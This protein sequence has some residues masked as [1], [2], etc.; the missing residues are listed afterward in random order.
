MTDY[1]FADFQRDDV[2]NEYGELE[3][4][5][6]FVYEACPDIEAIRTKVYAK[7]DAYNEKYP[8]K[9]MSLVIFDDALRHLLRI[10]RVINSPSGNMLLVGVGGSGKQSLTKLASFIAKQVMFQISLTKSYN[11]NSLKDDVKNLYIE[12]G[13]NGRQVTFI[14]TDAEVRSETFLEAINSLLGTG[15]IPGLLNKEDREVIP[16]SC[17]KVYMDEVGVKGEDPSQ[18][19]LWNFFIRRVKDCLH[20]VLAF[21]PVGVK[22]RER[23][24][25]FP[26]LFS[27]CSI[28][29]FLAWP[30]EALISVSSKALQA[31]KVD[32]SSEVKTELEKHMGRVHDLV[33]Q[34]TLEYF[35]KL[36]R[37]V[38]VTP[39]SYL[40]FIDMY[41]S[42]Y[43]SKYDAI[44]VESQS[45]VKGLERLAEASA[46]VEE[47]K[48]E[49]KQ[50][51]IKLK[52]ASDLTE[53]FLKELEVEN[54]KAQTKAD[55]VAVVTETCEAQRNQ[56]QTERDIANR[57][58]EQAIPF[59]RRAEAAVDS[60]KPK[61]ISELKQTKKPHDICRVV[62]DAVQILFQLP[63]VQVAPKP[64]TIAKENVPFIADSFEEHTKATL[65]GANFLKDLQEFSKHEKDSI[66][67]ETI[68]LLEPYLTL[69]APTGKDIYDAGVAKNANAALEGLCIWAGAMSDYHKQ[70]KIVK[71]KL[72]LLELKSVALK[73]AESKLEAA[74]AEL[75]EVEALKQ[76]LR[77][78]F[79]IQMEEKQALVERAQRTRKK[80]DQ[81][82]RLILSLQD[83]KLRWI[84]SSNQF[85][86]RKQRLVG[87]V[88]KAC[89]FV[90]YCGPFN[91]DYRSKLINDA[92]NRDLLERNIP[93]HPDLVLT[94]FLVDH[95][96]VGEWN[97]QKLPTDD[98]SI[99]NAIM[100]TRST[101]YPLMID[102]Q[103]QA[104]TWIRHREPSLDELGNI[105]TLNHPDLK[106]AL[107]MP[108]E[109]GLPVLIEA[110][111]NEVDPM[112]DPVL[113]RQYILKGR[114][115]LL[116]LA[117]Q[118][119]DFDDKFQLFMT[120][121]LANPHFSPE[122]AAKTTII[123]FTV[124][125]GGLEQQLL[126][127]LISKEQKS[128]EE[129]LTSLQ[130]E[131]TLNTKTLAAYEDQLLYKLANVTGSLLDEVDLIDVLAN[132]K[133][134]S[135]EV[136][137]KLRD[138]SEKTIE[139]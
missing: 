48:V 60:I 118:E 62:M 106:R 42:L 81:A 54:R 63:M 70:S 85:T 33:H 124:T 74:Q 19:T 11:D 79:D 15:E 128:L 13:P 78:K 24:Q 96:T 32:C 10:A 122:L 129:Q 82:N 133:V 44:D 113:E 138:A 88:A 3:F 50:E 30:E 31:F 83:N 97:L 56:I 55:E 27:T 66:N 126:G 80:M 102:P 53:K 28:D 14:M 51:D 107:S 112:L 57:D 95:A 108:L 16:L 38:Y 46:G 111:E 91:S 45:I 72:R 86:T 40:S 132:I 76:A 61:D 25:R 17:K 29:W 127:L 4:E 69:K 125:Q 18:T 23:A 110:I 20:M 73:E 9:K 105:I 123:D 34:V 130:E 120:S 93:V 103:N 68:E 104:V 137:E 59:L 52:D 115:K 2:I 36:R 135:R 116:K 109:N 98:L 77:K 134:K 101:R 87:D 12:A 26:A 92:F 7:L 22:F 117:D 8:S 39:K 119:M 89:A 94:D 121:R 131:V 65:I 136:N 47:L 67:E 139:I 35:Q 6:P 84:E 41:Q 37:H 64:F 90:S 58:L 100:V 1:L 5:A 21:S 75:A 43:Q 99:Q 114:K 71:P 49:L